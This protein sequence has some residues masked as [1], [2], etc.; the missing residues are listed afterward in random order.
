[1]STAEL[2]LQVEPLLT[3]EAESQF[4][5]IWKRF[6]R[7]K[8]AMAGIVIIAFFIAM[9]I[10][11]PFVAP[12][13]P[14]RYQDLTNTNAPP[15]AEHPLGTDKIGRD[16]LSRLMFG[17]SISLTVAFTVVLMSE[18]FG[19]I[20]GAISGFYGGRVDNLVQRVTDFMLSLPL[21]PM[22]LAVSAIFKDQFAIPGLP[23]EWNSAALIIVVLTVFGW[24]GACRLVRGQVLSLRNQDF[25]EAARALG[26][27]NRRIILRHM[28]PNALPPIIVNA[29][30]N[31]GFVIVIESALSFLTF[32]VQP[33]VPTWGNM[34][35]DYQAELWSEPVKV[36]FPGLSIFLCA[37][38]FNYIGDGLR[39]ALDPRLKR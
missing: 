25:T 30:L 2:E 39:D 32:G 1:M 33:P 10:L 19:S 11:A 22:L 34:L 36:F 35:A 5:V 15:S 6:R 28:I 4:R 27:S 17:A 21:L 26:V 29:T 13:D 12:Y 18:T 9:A 16:I 14:I 31:L 24:M 7:H 38:A 20:L 3:T 8:L 37:L 23:R